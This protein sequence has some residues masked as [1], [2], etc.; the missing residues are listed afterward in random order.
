MP[1]KLQL[2]S[3]H[4]RNDMMTADDLSIGTRIQN[5]IGNV[6]DRSPG[7]V[8]I[9]EI[10]AKPA[11]FWLRIPNFGRKSM[12]EL[13]L[14]LAEHGRMLAGDRHTLFSETRCSH[15]GRRVTLSVGSNGHRQAWR[16]KDTPLKWWMREYRDES[17]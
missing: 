13:R 8:S 3:S 9:N 2:I 17:S 12:T 7:M 10:C 4:E 5:A 14:A 6:F 15:C 1:T 16:I 11:E